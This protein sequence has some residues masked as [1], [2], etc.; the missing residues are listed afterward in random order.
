MRPFW[1]PALHVSL[2]LAILPACVAL[3]PLPPPVTTLDIVA[4]T[5]E[6]KPKEHILT[7]IRESRTI[8][9]LNA[10]EVKELI[11][12]G[13]AEEVLDYMLETRVIDL[14]QRLARQR[15]YVRPS[16]TWGLQFGRRHCY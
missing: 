7:L 10:T 16:F 5:E 3:R 12:Q 9:A 6:G 1:K 4:M 11:E 2:L 15:S 8:Y 13:V 14:E